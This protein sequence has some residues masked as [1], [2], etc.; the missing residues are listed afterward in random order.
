MLQKAVPGW[1]FAAAKGRN[2]YVCLGKVDEESFDS[3]PKLQ[4]WARGLRIDVNDGDVNSVPFEFELADWK[5]IGADD[6]CER[7]GCPFYGEGARGDTDCFVYA[8]KKRYMEAQIIVTNHT[9]VL[10]DA[11]LG[12]GTLLGPYDVL[13]VDEAHSFAEKAR[14]T[15]GIAFRPRTISRMIQL[16]HRMLMRA[17]V[18]YWGDGY[19][20]TYRGLEEAVFEPFQPHLKKLSLIHI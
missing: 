13:I 9:M 1:T 4:Q 12:V 7:K 18:P 14:D 11:Q 15:W 20:N 5:T 8:A 6:E 3:S 10:L 19:L 16:M 2:N 17:G